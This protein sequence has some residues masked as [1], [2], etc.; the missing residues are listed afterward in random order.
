MDCD[1]FLD[2][3]SA[4]MD[5]ETVDTAALDAHLATCSACREAAD[6]FK[7]DGDLL[8]RAFA[9]RAASVER[10]VIEQ[11][12]PKTKI[13][14]IAAVL[15]LAAAILLAFVVFLQPAPAKPIHAA[16]PMEIPTS[17][18]SVVRL[19]SGSEA[20]FESPRV[21][22]LSK[23][24]LYAKVAPS[25]EPY[26]VK[27]AHG[28]VT[29][30]GTEFD[31]RYADSG[32]V[33]TVVEGSTRFENIS[34]SAG[35]QWIGGLI[36][37]TDV[38]METEWVNDF[39]AGKSIDNEELASR[40]AQWIASLDNNVFEKKVRGMGSSALLPL[41]KF[42]LADKSPANRFKRNMGTKIFAE[43]APAWMVPELV[44]MLKLGDRAMF[45]AVAK[46]LER[47]TGVVPAVHAQEV[48]DND[49]NARAYAR[50][51]KWLQENGS[52]FPRPQ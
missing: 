4:R 6:D 1:R 43:I 46:A 17:D 42:L 48:I 36:I 26:H 27:T 11:I 50:W 7:S 25:S 8:R 3:I 51:K 39:L 12:K 18:G 32:V 22:R 24:Q 21:V 38:W 5:G 16:Q 29:V 20:L 41:A 2:M 49:G 44:E 23:G 19:N 47:H 15:G 52:R 31:V 37:Q 30:T 28:T 9:T 14:R 40:V 45:L 34:I 10:R 13:I 35:E 33:V